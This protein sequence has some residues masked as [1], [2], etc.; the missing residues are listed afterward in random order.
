MINP[1]LRTAAKD[2]RENGLKIPSW[3]FYVTIVTTCW[4]LG[5][6]LIILLFPFML[7]I[8]SP[9][10]PVCPAFSFLG[11]LWSGVE[12]GVWSILWHLGPGCSPV[13]S[14]TSVLGWLE[15]KPCRGQYV[16]ASMWGPV[17]G[18]QY[19]GPK[20]SRRKANHSGWCPWYCFWITIQRSRSFLCWG[21]TQPRGTME[22]NSRHCSKPSTNSGLTL[23]SAQGLGGR[24]L[25]PL[26]EYL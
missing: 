1:S 14:Q 5:L 22:R 23:D 12:M 18:G 20:V 11:F 26:S 24:F 13:T 7:L 4:P 17:C 16:G 25:F 19:V 3:S 15:G 21:V 8:K 10:T 9:P 2:N 6:P